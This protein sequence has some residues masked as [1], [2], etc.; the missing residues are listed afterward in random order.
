MPVNWPES[1]AG[2][3]ESMNLPRNTPPV[4]RDTR[5]GRAAAAPVA[6]LSSAR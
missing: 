1:A 3:L 2:S 6:K 4:S 5:P